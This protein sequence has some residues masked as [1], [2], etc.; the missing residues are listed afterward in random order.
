MKI[1]RISYIL[2]GLLGAVVLMFAIFIWSIG[3][4]IQRLESPDGKHV[5]TLIRADHIDRNYI[6]KLDGSRVFVTADF[7]PRSDVIF[8]ET[9][10]WDVSGKILVLEIARQKIIGYDTELNRRLGD[11]ELLEVELAPDSHLG[12]FF[13]EAPWP[14]IGRVYNRDDPRQESVDN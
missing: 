10:A 7:A 3:T 6:V 14:G 13:Y 12:E 11:S 2:L 5:A 4:T 9:L 1:S 8:R